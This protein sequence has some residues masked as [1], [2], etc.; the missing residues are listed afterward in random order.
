MIADAPRPPAPAP[1]RV[2]CPRCSARTNT[3]PSHATLV[4]SE[5]TRAN[6]T[7]SIAEVDADHP[8]RLPDETFDRGSIAAGYP[9]RLLGQV[10]VDHV[11]VHAAAIVVDLVAAGDL[12][13]H[14]QMSPSRRC[15]SAGSDLPDAPELRHV[16][17][18]EPHPGSFRRRIDQD[19]APRPDDHRVTVR[20]PRLLRRSELAPLRRRGH[21]ALIL[22]RARTEQDLPVRDAGLVLELRGNR[23]QLGAEC[24]ESTEQLRE[25]E[26][27]T[28][29]QSDPHVLD[30][31]GDELRARGE[32]RGLAEGRLPFEVDVEEMDLPIASR[33]AH[34]SDRRAGRC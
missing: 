10:P 21:E 29:G 4:P 26:V 28:D 25:A 19:L 20:A 17:V 6:P 5:I 18:R 9:V 8:R 24:H 32:G 30:R 13:T 7:C 15:S 31:V 34:P 14:Q 2:P 1:R 16:Q 33:P 27:V 23:E 12:P 11:D 3:S 22:D